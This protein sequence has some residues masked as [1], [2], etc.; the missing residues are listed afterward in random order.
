MSSNQPRPSS[1]EASNLDL[2]ALGDA[3]T[4]SPIQEDNQSKSQDSTK[5]ATGVS[6]TEPYSLGDDDDEEEEVATGSGSGSNSGSKEKQVV[7]NQN[8]GKKAATLESLSPSTD[9]P[10]S[11]VD[12]K[13]GSEQQNQ[14]TTKTDG[15]GQSDSLRSGMNVAEVN[16]PKD[17]PQVEAIKAMFPDLDSETISAVLVVVDGDVDAG[18]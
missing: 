13:V 4:D 1:I 3:L 10:S 15:N 2:T 14:K 18:E 12:E 9:H 11:F 5:E 8:E 17:S 16:A 7:N 6:E